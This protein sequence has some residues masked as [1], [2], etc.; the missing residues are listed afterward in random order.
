M[1]VNGRR[2]CFFAALV[3]ACSNAAPRSAAPVPPGSSASAIATVAAPPAVSASASSVATLPLPAPP[4]KDVCAVS[5]PKVVVPKQGLIRGFDIGHDGRIYWVQFDPMDSEAR[6]FNLELGNSEAKPQLVV[7]LKVHGDPGELVVGRDGF[8]LGVDDLTRG[9]CGSRVMWLGREAKRAISVSAP[10]CLFGPKRAGEGAE[11]IWATS[12]TYSHSM[13]VFVASSPPPAGVAPLP[14][15]VEGYFDAIAHGGDGVYVALENGEVIR[16]RLD[17][18]EE[19]VVP[20]VY[21]FPADLSSAL[22]L[23]GQEIY[24]GAVRGLRVLE[25]L[26]TTR[27]GGAAKPIGTFDVQTTV[28]YLQASDVGLLLHLPGGGGSSADRLLFIDPTGSCPN[29]EL[30]IPNRLLHVGLHEDVVYVLR[31][32]GIVATSFA[33]RAKH[34]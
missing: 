5:E 11:A 32:E 29:V 7:G 17:G 26:R 13:Q 22:A 8:W 30:P 27:A 20:P 34:R 10:S 31:E 1:A 28:S 21:R 14:R 24:I 15:K 4:A 19:R 2:G 16:R 9:V 3:L 25:L 23:H 12:K 33:A 18:A 6:I